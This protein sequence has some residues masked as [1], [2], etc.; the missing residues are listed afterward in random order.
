MYKLVDDATK[1]MQCYIIRRMDDG[2]SVLLFDL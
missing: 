2:H 1:L